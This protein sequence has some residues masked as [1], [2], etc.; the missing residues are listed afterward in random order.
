MLL[1][2]GGSKDRLYQSHYQSY[3]SVHPLE[4]HSICEH[5]Y[6]LSLQEHVSDNM[7]MI[8]HFIIIQYHEIIIMSLYF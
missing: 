6:T 3:N 1:V 2:S 8:S 7:S 4:R 5:D